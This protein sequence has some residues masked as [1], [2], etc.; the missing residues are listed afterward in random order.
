MFIKRALWPI[1]KQQSYPNVQDVVAAK[2][3]KYLVKHSLPV[4]LA[5]MYSFSECMHMIDQLIEASVDAMLEDGFT[6]DLMRDY[7]VNLMMILRARYPKE[8]KEDWKNEAFLGI[9]C[10]LVY[11][12]EEA[13]VY[14]QNAYNQLENPPQSLIFAY[15]SAGRG[16]DQFLTQPQVTELLHKGIEKSVTYE[17]ALHMAAL[18][19]EQK[20]FE[21]QEYWK[22]KAVEAE[23][24]G[25]HTP[26]ITPNV[27]KDPFKEKSRY[28]YEE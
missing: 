19:Y 7:S 20:D 3:W 24:N 9:V 28:Q 6:A 23:Q 11:R 18:A 26:M 15:I 14:I 17:A 8:W 13:F 22:A 10:A 16:P 21:K 5:D 12:E 25:I 1:K 4:N 2:N 27:L